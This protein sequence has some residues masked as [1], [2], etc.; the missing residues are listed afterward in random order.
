MFDPEG[1]YLFMT[2]SQVFNPNYSDFDNTFVY[3]NS[4]QI[5]VI[6]L[7]KD[8]VAFLAPKDDVVATKEEKK[9]EEEQ[10]KTLKRIKRKGGN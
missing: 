4:S 6:T 8:S 10:K 7:S 3:N 2:T 1:K 5:G 9:K